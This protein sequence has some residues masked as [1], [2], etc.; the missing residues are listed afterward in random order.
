MSR[1]VIWKLNDV[2]SLASGKPEVIES[3]SQARIAGNEYIQKL[4]DEGENVIEVK[5]QGRKLIITLE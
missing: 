3:E 4:K 2:V 1:T 5:E